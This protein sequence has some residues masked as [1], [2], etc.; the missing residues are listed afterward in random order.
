MSICLEN[1]EKHTRFGTYL[2]SEQLR[3]RQACAHASGLHIYSNVIEVHNSIVYIV[4]KS[5]VLM[6]KM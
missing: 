6:P 4:T 1:L 2:I 3:L 5:C